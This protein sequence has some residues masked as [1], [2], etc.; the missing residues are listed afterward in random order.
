VS[1]VSWLISIFLL[2]NFAQLLHQQQARSATSAHEEREEKPAAAQDEVTAE[3]SGA[4]DTPVIELDLMIE[5]VGDVDKQ[6]RDSPERK[7]F[8]ESIL[9]DLS[10]ASPL[11]IDPDVRI[12]ML[13]M[14]EKE[15][16]A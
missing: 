3:Q 10:S 14:N 8:R 12:E 16:H 5:Q 7:A 2:T 11:A 4:L 13:K 1:K 9:R 6:G 15:G